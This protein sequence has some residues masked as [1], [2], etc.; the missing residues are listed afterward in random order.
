MGTVD[1]MSQLEW[2]NTWYVSVN[3]EDEEEDVGSPREA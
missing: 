3:D 2:E 1:V